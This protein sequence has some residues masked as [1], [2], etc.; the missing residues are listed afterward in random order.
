MLNIVSINPTGLFSY[1]SQATV[2]L[3]GRGI[4]HLMGLNHDRGNSANG[5]G[6]TSLINAMCH[7]LFGEDPTGASDVDI[8][9]KV[10]GNGAWGK[11]EYI[12]SRNER[13]RIILARGWKNKAKYP[14]E[15]TETEPSLLHV[16]GHR[17]AGTDLYLDLWDGS[18]WIDKREAKSLDTRKLIIKT[19]GM[20]YQ[21]FLTTSYLSQSDGFKFIKAKNKD[22]MQIISE[23]QGLGVWDKAVSV[24]RNDLKTKEIE[25][26]TT[27]GQA[28]SCTAVLDYLV[29]PLSN[30]GESALSNEI[31]SLTSSLHELEYKN[32]VMDADVSRITQAMSVVPDVVLTAEAKLKIII[33]KAQALK[34]E[35]EQLQA[36]PSPKVVYEHGKLTNQIS[37]DK[38]LAQVSIPSP[39]DD[40]RSQYNSLLGQ[41]SL[42]AAKLKSAMAGDGVCDRCGSTITKEH[43][44]KHHSD[45]NKELFN[46]DSSLAYVEKNLQNAISEHTAAVDRTHNEINRIFHTRLSELTDTYNMQLNDYNAKLNNIYNLESACSNEY[47]DAET[48]LKTAKNAHTSGLQT[49]LQSA[50]AARAGIQ[51]NLNE[52]KAKITLLTST[53][54]AN[55]AAKITHAATT[56]QLKSINERVDKS[57]NDISI[58]KII[59]NA[60]GDRGI[61]AHKFGSV[62]GVLNELVQDY[63]SILTNGYVQVWFSPWKDKSNAK[64]TDDVV[65]EVQIFVREGPKDEVELSLYSGAESQQV[66]LAIICAFWALATSQGGGTNILCLDEVFSPFDNT[67]ATLAVNLL[68][69]LRGSHF[70]TIIVITHDANVKD[71]LPYD[72]L[73][74]A[75]KRGH[76]TTLSVKN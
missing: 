53:K 28:Q 10:W 34:T 66:T 31:A 60:M 40:I 68:N 76:L 21:Q 44:D 63:I 62:I 50:L 65:A 46:I 26:A 56:E 61:K 2:R 17:Y 36:L 64:T 32:S 29:K 8:V 71:I 6:K 33:D 1:G 43:I 57:Q 47:I 18:R 30:N 12:N 73:W 55:E 54:A 24:L 75:E 59:I 39:A 38:A 13:W 48:A 22:R 7:I 41:R 74:M 35:R 67:N 58:T 72:A 3:D 25:L 45:L 23:L 16:Q 9:N 5:A 49:K 51:S 11:V 27:I 4:V 52:A 14:D 19:V 15:A 37:R 70:G 20:S 69:K 42:I